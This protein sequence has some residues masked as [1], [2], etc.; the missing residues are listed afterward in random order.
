MIPP[1]TGNGMSMAFESAELALEPLVGF[2]RGGLSWEAAHRAIAGSCD[3]RF[4]PRL[5]RAALLQWALFHPPA[6]AT[7]EFLLA[8]SGWFWDRVFRGTR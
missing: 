6:R 3:D 1:V 4:A 2:S 8:H 7:L 5:R